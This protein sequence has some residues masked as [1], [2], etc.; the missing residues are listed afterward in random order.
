[1]RRLTILIVFPLLAAHVS[2]S[3]AQVVPPALAVGDPYHLVFVTHAS[4]DG[5]SADIAD[6]YAFVQMQA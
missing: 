4:R 3:E 5:A 6:Y 1:M 2:R